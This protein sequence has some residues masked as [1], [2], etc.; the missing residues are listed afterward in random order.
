MKIIDNESRKMFIA[1][2]KD[3]A[4]NGVNLFVGSGLTKALCK[5][6]PTWGELLSRALTEL[7]LAQELEQ[8]MSNGDSF[9]KI[10]S[11]ICE[12]LSEKLCVSFDDAVSVF[13]TTICSLS[14]FY[15][16]EQS[17]CGKKLLEAIEGIQPS[18]IVTTNYDLCIESILGEKSSHIGGQDP[19]SNTGCKIPVY[20]I[21]GSVLNPEDIVITQEDYIRMFRPGEYRQSSV[22][23]ILSS[24]PTIFVSYSINDVNVKTYIDW[25]KEVYNMN[26]QYNQ[27]QI[28]YDSNFPFPRAG[29]AQVCFR[30]EG[31]IFKTNDVIGFLH[32]LSR[33][34]NIIRRRD[35]SVSLHDENEIYDI[36]VLKDNPSSINLY[37]RGVERLVDFENAVA[38]FIKRAV[39]RRDSLNLETTILAVLHKAEKKCYEYGQF[40][41]YAILAAM[42][43]GI[44]RNEMVMRI[45]KLFIKT[46]NCLNISVSNAGKTTG[47]SYLADAYLRKRM[48]ELKT[49]VFEKILSKAL[50]NEF[51]NLQTY[52]NIDN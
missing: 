38:D 23:V 30:G 40:H 47:K 20:H 36:D 15:V 1:L 43:I 8:C 31:H 45:P 19:I 4:K 2:A 22:P 24:A 21:H 29:G 50:K 6:A 51:P 3:C 5:S 32:L 7:G 42:C 48:P 28:V 34:V 13:K 11:N 18:Y 12:E 35:E 9:P 41:S 26:S 25:C 10:A 49:E 37:G 14:S 46:I 27:Y 52:L 16:S 33:C 17:E 39:C 44:L